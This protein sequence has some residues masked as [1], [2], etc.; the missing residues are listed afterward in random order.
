[1]ARRSTTPK[2]APE[3][4]VR[5]IVQVAAATLRRRPLLDRAGWYEPLPEPVESSTR[6]AAALRVAVGSSG[7]NTA[8]LAIGEDLETGEPCFSDPFSDYPAIKS[9]TRCVIGDVGSGKSANEKTCGVMRPLLLG[10]RVA[11]VD[12]KDQGGQGEYTPLAHA[13]NIEPIRFALDG[14]GTKINILDPEI[15]TT[16]SQAAATQNQLLRAVAAQALGRELRQR[17]G[18]ALEVARRQA[19]HEAK[20]DK[21]VA[22]IRSL[23]PAML[24]P[25]RESAEQAVTSVDQLREFGRDVAYALNI[26]IDDHLTGLVDGPTDP[27]IQLNNSL[28]V[29]DISA[30]PDSG[31]AVPIAMAIINTWLSNVLAAQAMPVPTHFVVEEGWHLVSGAFAE[32]ARSNSKLARGKGLAPEY[33]IHHLSDIDKASAAM[34]MIREAG[35]VLLYRQ[36]RAD[37]AEACVETFNLPRES[38]QTLMTLA[39]GTFIFVQTGRPPRLIQHLRSQIERELTNTDAVMTSTATMSLTTQEPVPVTPQLVGAVQ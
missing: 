11:V 26:M 27:R 2:P 18:K 9:P 23:V 7:A 33:A 15:G 29:F 13:L 5:R 24:N 38:K 34:A 16:S 1:M 25:T 14:T 6:Q 30:L 12:K 4:P 39:D 35:H 32:V 22:D 10:R 19:V 21:K 37:D 17:E 36:S 28:T 20:I 3:T 8:A 31:P